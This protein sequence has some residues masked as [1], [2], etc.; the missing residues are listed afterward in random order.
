MRKEILQ[1]AFGLNEY[2]SKILAVLTTHK[3]LKA[4]DISKMS[5]VPRSRIYDVADTLMMKGLI[6]ELKNWTPITFEAHD[7]K[8]MLENYQKML[9]LKVN[10]KI[11]SCKV[12]LK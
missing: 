11:K 3:K 1:V 7:K 6:K 9:L 4:S 10:E 12:L 8:T 5:G 2:E